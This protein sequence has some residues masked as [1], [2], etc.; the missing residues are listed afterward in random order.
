VLAGK[1]GHTASVTVATFSPEGQRVLTVSG[2][3]TAKVWPVDGKG[4]PIVLTGDPTG[5]DGLEWGTFSPD[6]KRVLTTSSEGR[7]WIWNADGSGKPVILRR[8]YDRA[9]Q[10][11][12]SRAVF[13]PDGQ[14]IVTA[15]EVDGITCV[16]KA[17]GGDRPIVLQGHGGSVLDAKFS[18]D[19]TRVVTASEDGTA[20]VWRAT[21][22]E[23]LTYLRQA[24]T[25][26]LTLDERLI[27]LRE[28]EPDALKNY[29]RR[30]RAFGRTP[31]PAGN[32]FK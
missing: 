18:A 31:S 22:G 12:I 15:G 1:H 5:K 32:G 20:Q 24:T 14:R 21:W 17:E 16:W 26:T 9:H 7:V 29:E 3:G 25:A 2:D 6:G 28:K 10:G 13:S 23:L 27:L 4:T 30:E 11:S 19:G 8:L